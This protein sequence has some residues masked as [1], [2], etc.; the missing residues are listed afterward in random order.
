ME[1]FEKKEKSDNEKELKPKKVFIEVGT[2]DYP[3]S[4]VGKKEFGKNDIYVGLDLDEGRLR[5][6][7]E[8]T[9]SVG[10]LK[11]NIYFLRSDAGELPF[12]NETSG[13]VFLG[14][15]F[16]DPSIPDRKKESFLKEAKR[17]L[18]KGGRIIIKET[19]TPYSKKSLEELSQKYG[20]VIE[21]MIQLSSPEWEKEV[22]VYDQLAGRKEITAYDSY[23]A[24]LITKEE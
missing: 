1:E 16:G 22:S 23:F 20:F 17:I 8:S 5:E 3:V 9:D 15:V 6:G 19:N 14:N 10:K 2:H 24:I 12:G 4:W 7:R 13:E 21:K 11:K 18:K